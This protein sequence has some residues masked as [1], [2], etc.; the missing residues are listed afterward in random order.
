MI[1]TFLFVSMIHAKPIC[2]ENCDENGNP[3]PRKERSQGELHGIA[4]PVELTSTK[5]AKI[6]PHIEQKPRKKLNILV[7]NEADSN[8]PSYFAALPANYEHSFV[9]TAK[10]PANDV[11]SGIHAG[12]KIKVVIRQNIKASPNVPTPV[13]GEVLVGQFKGATVYGE[14]TLESDLKRIV[15]KFTGLSGAGLTSSYSIQGRGLDPQGRIGVEGNFHAEDWKYGIA[16]L[17]STG[18]AIA[19][20]SQVERNPTIAGGYAESPSASNA[21]K[22]GV[23]GSLGKVADRLMERAGSV[24]G[25]T[26]VEGPIFMTVIL[27]APPKALQ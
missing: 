5:S 16:S 11:L 17:F 3:L 24:P 22:K 6:P 9:F 1:I 23:A 15:L 13:V 27:D 14:A 18:A 4:E 20:D 2:V 8:L 26:E 19:I 7:E 12:T 10:E 25:F 21:V